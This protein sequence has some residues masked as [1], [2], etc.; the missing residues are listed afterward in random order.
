MIEEKRA[1]G[2]A[3]LGIFHD[4]EVRE[5]LGGRIVDVSGFSARAK[6]A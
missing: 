3:I 6:V 2:T 4:A 5:R 1:R